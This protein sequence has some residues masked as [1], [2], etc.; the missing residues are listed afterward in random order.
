MR[1]GPIG[2]RRAGAVKEALREA[3][4]TSCRRAF[5]CARA[6]KA[7]S[8][9]IIAQTDQIRQLMVP[10]QASPTPHPIMRKTIKT[11]S[12]MAIQRRICFK[13]GSLG[14]VLFLIALD[15]VCV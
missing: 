11:A 8:D 15:P 1:S 5:C 6:A 2:G 7:I 10:S 9:P 3:K 13:C 12:Q 4:E 14:V